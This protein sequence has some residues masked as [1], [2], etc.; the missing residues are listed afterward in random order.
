ME[1][2]FQEKLS[3]S[4]SLNL[5]PPK[6]HLIPIQMELKYTFLIIVFCLPILLSGQARIVLNSDFETPQLPSANSYRQVHHSSVTGWST[7]SSSGMMEFWRAPFQGVVP[8]SGQQH[9]ELNANQAADLYFDA[10]M[11]NGE[12]LTWSFYHRGRAGLDSARLLIGLPGAEVEVLRF[13]TD[14]TAWVNYTGTFT[15]TLGN[16]TVRFRFQ[17]VSTAA[18]NLT[19]GNFIDDVQMSH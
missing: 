8:A 7:T 13:G 10:C 12:S 6:D 1:L 11:F 15:N 19:V 9:I 3:N 16:T 17:P 5:L 2:K 14:N 4:K 18:G